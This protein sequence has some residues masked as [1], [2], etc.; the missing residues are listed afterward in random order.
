MNHWDRGRC[1]KCGAIGHRQAD[2]RSG[3]N[4][5]HV[6]FATT[7]TTS[8]WLVDSGATSHMTFCRDDFTTYETLVT[9]L[10]ISSADGGSMRAIGA[11]SVQF[12]ALN[13]TKVTFTGVLHVPNLSRRLISDPSLTDKGVTVVFRHKVCEI[14]FRGEKLM[15]VARL[16]KLYAAVAET[17]NEVHDSRE[18]M[19]AEEERETELWHARL[20][21]VDSIRLESIVKVCDVL[22]KKLV[23][24]VNDMKLCVGCIR[25]KMSVDKFPSN[26]RG[27]VKTTSVFQLVHTDVMGPMSVKSQGK[28][29]YALTFIYDYSHFM[30]EVDE[31]ARDNME[32]DEDASDNMEVDEDAS[33][34]MEVDEEGYDIVPTVREQ[35]PSNT[36]LNLLPEATVNTVQQPIREQLP[37]ETRQQLPPPTEQQQL[38]YERELSDA[39]VFPSTC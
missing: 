5:E 33:D 23:A 21:H 17:T 25:D 22:P 35:I 31:D 38:G 2:C 39:I 32:V 4:N 12:Q 27:H 9:T 30:M 37:V 10:C 28:A 36:D 16:G 13:V 11:G 14:S 26:V 20:G 15:G 19:K 6:F 29:H 24:Y 18:L 8:D 34:S 1:F 3:D 7:Q